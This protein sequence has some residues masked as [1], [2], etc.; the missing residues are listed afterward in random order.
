[1][2]PSIENDDISS[3]EGVTKKDV[4]VNIGI[5]FCS[6]PAK[7]FGEIKLSKGSISHDL[8][9][10]SIV[11]VQQGASDVYKCRKTPR[12]TDETNSLFTR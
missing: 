10:K 2:G 5:D 4:R 6:K 11:K 1:M 12:Q 8:I 9:Q 3:M 7:R